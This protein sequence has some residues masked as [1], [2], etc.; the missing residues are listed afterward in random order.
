M[1]KKKEIK[2]RIKKLLASLIYEELD[3]YEYIVASTR[4]QALEWVL[5]P[6]ELKE[7]I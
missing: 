7:D 6:K 3:E 2:E 5:E 4:V 1:K